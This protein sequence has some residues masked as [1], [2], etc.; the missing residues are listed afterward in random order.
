M[1]S[2]EAAERLHV[3]HQPQGHDVLFFHVQDPQLVEVNLM[4]HFW[5]S[6]SFEL[7]EIRNQ[8]T[9]V[10]KLHGVLRHEQECRSKKMTTKPVEKI[11][12]LLM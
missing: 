12:L 1:V 6:T 8:L 3:H 4:A 10:A 9:H 11:K 2:K 7:C 5:Y